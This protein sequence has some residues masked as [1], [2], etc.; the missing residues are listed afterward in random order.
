MLFQNVAEGL[1]LLITSNGQAKLSLQLEKTED[2]TLNNW[3]NAGDAVEWALPL[4]EKKEFF[5]VRSAPSE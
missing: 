1:M 2:L 4:G 5:R 3:T